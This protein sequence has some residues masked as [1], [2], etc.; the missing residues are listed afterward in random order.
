[1]LKL[2]VVSRIFKEN[3]IGP[4]EK[5]EQEHRVTNIVVFSLN[6]MEFSALNY[7]LLPNESN[8]GNHGTRLVGEIIFLSMVTNQ[9]IA[10]I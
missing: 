4:S 6:S 8:Y 1:M 7:N 2:F 3:C 10:K 5:E 9:K